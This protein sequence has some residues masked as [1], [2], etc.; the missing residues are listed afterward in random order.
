MTFFFLNSPNKLCFSLAK[1][2]AY[3]N[4]PPFTGLTVFGVTF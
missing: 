4:L 2:D 1:F 3:R